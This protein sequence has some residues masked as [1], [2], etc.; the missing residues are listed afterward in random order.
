VMILK[1]D[2]NNGV[3]RLRCCPGGLDETILV[4]G[5]GTG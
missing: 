3:W 2:S 5:E 4:R 1:C